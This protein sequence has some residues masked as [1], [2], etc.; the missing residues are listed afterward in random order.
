MEVAAG[1]TE[2]CFQMANSSK[3]GLS[4][5]MVDFAQGKMRPFEN[6][7]ML[8]YYSLIFVFCF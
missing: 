5:E 6:Q 3:T 4:Y 7:N 1:I 2:T 8:R